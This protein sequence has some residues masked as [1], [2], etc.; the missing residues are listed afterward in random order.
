MRYINFTKDVE[1]IINIH[2]FSPCMSCGRWIIVVI[3]QVIAMCVFF[4][5][6]NCTGGPPLTHFAV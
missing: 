2:V 5:N 1:K 6:P 4:V 3:M